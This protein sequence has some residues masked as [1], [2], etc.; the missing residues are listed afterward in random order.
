MKRRR[1]K[2]IYN[3]T[4]PSSTYRNA[5]Y[6]APGRDPWDQQPGETDSAYRG[7]QIYLHIDPHRRSLLAA[8]RIYVREIF[9]DQPKR[10]KNA[11]KLLEAPTQF[12]VWASK[13]RW[14]TRARAWDKRN[15]EL[16]RKEEIEKLKQM[17]EQE[18]QAYTAVAYRALDGL[19]KKDHS[20][21]VN[22]G[23][24]TLIYG[25]DLA[26][27]GRAR[28]IGMDI[29]VDDDGELGDLPGLGRLGPVELETLA[30]LLQS[31]IEGEEVVGALPAP[32][33]GQAGATCAPGP[34]AGDPGAGQAGAPQSDQPPRRPPPRVITKRIGRNSE[35]RRKMI[36]GFGGEDEN[37]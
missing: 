8:Y 14:V 6:F 5:F 3:P 30:G 7:F 35:S 36:P 33:A 1:K 11:D 19:V 9:P 16:L 13:Y 22:A 15:Q 32:S 25:M 2:D 4:K 21:W 12:R 28:A 26:F 10:H 37:N 31:A 23:I 18:I 29:G 24:G 20:E 27:K 17:K 34:S